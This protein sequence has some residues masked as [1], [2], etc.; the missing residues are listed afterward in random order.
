[1]NLSARMRL[2]CALLLIA[3][4]TPAAAS[5]SAQPLPGLRSFK[6][7][8]TDTTPQGST[9]RDVT[10]VAPDKLRL[11]IVGTPLV[12]VAIAHNVWLRGQNHQWQKAQYAPGVDPLS[13]VRA[14]FD[15]A[16]QMNG[17]GVH[18]EGVS[19]LN[20]RAVKV[21]DIDPPAKRGYEG[22]ITRFWIGV[23][24]GYPHKIEQRKGP[25]VFTAV[26]S[27]WNQPLSVS[28]P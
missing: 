4:A 7:R 20:G 6:V 26:Y 16:R 8:L 3:A 9:S 17:P 13:E 25:Y 22:R 5:T 11:E 24:D 12:V 28:G 2:A 23:S 21:Y 27:A 19:R 1:M 10:Y 15:I 14:T 18:L